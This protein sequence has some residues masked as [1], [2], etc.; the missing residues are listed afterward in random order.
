MIEGVA[1]HQAAFAHK[2]RNDHRVGGKT[3]TKGDGILAAY[4][5]CYLP[6]KLYMLCCGACNS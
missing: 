3:H 4:K 6:V 2:S 1:E 5:L